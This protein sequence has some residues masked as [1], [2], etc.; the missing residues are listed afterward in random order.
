MQGTSELFW[1][2]HR[3]L[4]GYSAVGRGRQ[5]DFGVGHLKE[6][7][8]G[9]VVNN[10]LRLGKA[11]LRALQGYSAVGHTRD[12]WRLDTLL[13]TARKRGEHGLLKVQK[14]HEQ[15]CLLRSTCQI[16]PPKTP[17]QEALCGNAKQK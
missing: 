5:G 2:E 15:I 14:P 17:T 9:A 16:T 12:T 1:V 3:A 7:W 10:I 6:L 11:N 4:Q 13:G 8:D